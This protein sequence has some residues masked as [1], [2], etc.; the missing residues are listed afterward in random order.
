MCC[1]DDV[2]LHV[3]ERVQAER[4]GPCHLP[5]AVSL[6][7]GAKA[8]A[9]MAGAVGDS[10]EQ[11]GVEEAEQSN[12]KEVVINRVIGLVSTLALTDNQT[13]AHHKSRV[14]T[15]QRRWC[16]MWCAGCA[17]HPRGCTEP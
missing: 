5:Q 3:R 9:H 11:H 7:A 16:A 6:L 4:C 17:A 15:T 10:M 14:R 1:S 8:A 2:C 12:G 13:M